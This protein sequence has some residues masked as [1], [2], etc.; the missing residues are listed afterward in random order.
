MYINNMLKFTI[1]TTSARTSSHFNCERPLVGEFVVVSYVI[2][3][4]NP[5]RACGFIM[6][7]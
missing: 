7:S 1:I 2:P 5:R 3:S 6:Q 4:P